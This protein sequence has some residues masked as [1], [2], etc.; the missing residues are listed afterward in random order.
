ML[1]TQ[2]GWNEEI[3]YHCDGLISILVINDKKF[4]VLM[5]LSQAILTVTE[6]ISDLWWLIIKWQVMYIH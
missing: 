5:L 6:Q 1:S 4:V 3:S 2:V